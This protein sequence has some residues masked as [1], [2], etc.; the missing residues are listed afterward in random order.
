MGMG[1]GR[2]VGVGVE[3]GVVVG[4]SGEV[5]DVSWCVEL[6]CDAGVGVWL[7]GEEE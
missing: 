2:V 3:A 6:E 4:V 7:C 1:M 5:T